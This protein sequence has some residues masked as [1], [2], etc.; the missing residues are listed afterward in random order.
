[1]S[2]SDACKTFPVNRN[3]TMM[4]SDRLLFKHL[5]KVKETNH[6]EVRKI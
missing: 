2:L 4:T 3:I 6:E 1:M 5:K